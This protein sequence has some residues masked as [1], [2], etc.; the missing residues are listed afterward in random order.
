[1]RNITMVRVA[2]L[3]TLGV[4]ESFAQIQPGGWIKS[5]VPFFQQ[6]EQS[7]HF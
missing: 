7:H 6:C 3:L 2:L 5:S 1:M 4:G